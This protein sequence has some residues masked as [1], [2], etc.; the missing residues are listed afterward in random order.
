MEVGLLALLLLYGAELA[1]RLESGETKSPYR[2]LMVLVCVALVR[3]DG[4]V[5]AMTIGACAVW[6]MTGRRLR[7]AAILCGGAL[8]AATAHFMFSRFY[9]GSWLPN[10]YYLKLV[11][12]PTSARLARGVAT[13]VHCAMTFLPVALGLAVVN[14]KA[15]RSPARAIPLLVPLALF[16]YSIYVGG[17]VWEWMPYST[18]YVTTTL[19]LLFVAASGCCGNGKVSERT[20]IV[21]VLVAGSALLLRLVIVTHFELS[22]L[23]GVRSAVALLAFAGGVVSMTSRKSPARPSRT[24]VGATAGMAVFATM[25]L[26]GYSEWINEGGVHVSDDA[27][28]TRL[29]IRIRDSTRADARIAVVG[30]GNLPYFVERPCIDLLGPNDPVIAKHVPVT[31]FVPGHDKFDYDYSIGRLQPDLVA[32]EWLRPE[33]F[34][35][36][37]RRNG[38]DLVF[39]EVSVKHGSSAVAIDQLRDALA[40]DAET[41]AW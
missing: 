13:F 3:S 37:L 6:S 8:F 41:P 22:F 39:G 5:P 30:A 16:A 38:Y 10:A 17:D 25:S 34:H 29:A 19:P 11:G 12:A 33:Q 24:L 2:L 27:A 14:R 28:S 18:R 15:F 7:T 9:Y 4:I 31:G 20:G 36:V 1:L 21:A 40:K 23:N 35:E 32:Q 26:P